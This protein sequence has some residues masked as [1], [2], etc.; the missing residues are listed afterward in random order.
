MIDNSKNAIFLARVAEEVKRPSC[1][2]FEVSCPECK[3]N[4]QSCLFKSV[5]KDCEVVPNKKLFKCPKC[6]N[7]FEISLNYR[8]II[9]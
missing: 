7:I 4:M 3:C 6:R 1:Y 2:A 9:T 8:P 5:I